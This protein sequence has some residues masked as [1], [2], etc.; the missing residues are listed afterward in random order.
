MSEKFFS[1]SLEEN[2]QLPCTLVEEELNQ[3]KQEVMKGQA[4]SFEKTKPISDSMRDE[5]IAQ[6]SQLLEQSVNFEDFQVE[7]LL[8]T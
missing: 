8:S 7:S 3:E 2:F 1:P 5:S 6:L 4:A